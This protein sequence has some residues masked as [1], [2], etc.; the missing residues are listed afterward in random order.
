M[1]KPT[2]NTDQLVSAST[3]AKTFGAV[4]KKA[5][6]LPQFITDNG[7]VDTV[8]MEYR[9]FEEM[10]ARLQELED[11]E[12]ERVLQERIERLEENPSVAIP[13]K[14]VRRTE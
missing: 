14:S 1:K 7:E 2:F 9:Y 12:E 4:R 13:W 5:K 6:I 10:Y 8:V 3:A 11:N